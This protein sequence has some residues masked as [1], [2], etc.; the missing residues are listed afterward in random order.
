MADQPVPISARPL[1]E[2]GSERVPGMTKDDVQR[3]SLHFHTLLHRSV[4]TALGI[5]QGKDQF[6]RVIV[7]PFKRRQR[8]KVDG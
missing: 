6:P 7:H 1:H 3:L 5:E 4:P 8:G 2:C